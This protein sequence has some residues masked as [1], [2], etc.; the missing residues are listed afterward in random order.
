MDRRSFLTA[1]ATVSLSGAL[2]RVGRTADYPF[3]PTEQSIAALQHALATGVVTSEALTAAYLARIARYDQHGPGYHSVLAVN[4]KAV[5][6][7]RAL[8]AERKARKLRGPLHGIPILIKDNIETAD[9]VATTGGS[10]VLA[11]SMRG[12][13]AALV[14]RL[15]AAGAIVLGKAN[16]SEWANFRSTHSSS[17]WSAL[18]GHTRNAYDRERNAS[19]SSSGSGVAAAASF[20]AAA[21]GTETNGS[22]LSPSSLNGLVGLKPT[23]GVVSR[24]GVIPISGRQDTPGPMCRSVADAALIAGVIAET[25]LGYGAHAADLEAFRLRGL[26]IGV[27]PVAKQAHPETAGVFARARAALESEGG[28]LIELKPPAAFD[29]LD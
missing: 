20:C 6:A 8:D 12:A 28:V 1:A 22:I 21:I 27:L 29:E 15:R 4:P 7:A 9:P 14:A 17:G 18:G 2:E 11:R 23:V 3:D 19:G 24:Q 5:D 16:L 10:L 13:D 26:K 25:A